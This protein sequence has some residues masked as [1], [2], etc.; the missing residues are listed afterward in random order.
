MCLEFAPDAGVGSYVI[1][2]AGFAIA[3]LDE[4]AAGESLELFEEIGIIEPVIEPEPTP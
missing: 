4:A 2:H 1:V 3:V